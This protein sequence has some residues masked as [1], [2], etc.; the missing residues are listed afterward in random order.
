MPYLSAARTASLPATL[1]TLFDCGVSFP[2]EDFGSPIINSSAS[3]SLKIVVSG[4][5]PTQTDSHQPIFK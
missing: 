5:I 2:S 1:R 3:Y 4:Y